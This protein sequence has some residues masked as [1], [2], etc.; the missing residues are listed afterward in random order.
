MYMYIVLYVTVVVILSR[1]YLIVR[2]NRVEN[3]YI[4][5]QFR[6]GLKERRE[7]KHSEKNHR[8]AI[9]DTSIL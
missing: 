3:R 7:T 8:A 2:K 4:C 5:A 9:E 1:I 6:D